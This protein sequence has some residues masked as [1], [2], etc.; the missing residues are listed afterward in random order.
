MTPS[1]TAPRNASVEQSR[2]AKKAKR[3]PNRVAQQ[4]QSHPLGRGDRIASDLFNLAGRSPLVS[5]FLES[6]DHPDR[7]SC[8]RAIHEA[9]TSTAA[10]T[11]LASRPAATATATATAV[12]SA[13]S[14]K[15]EA[16]TEAV[17]EAAAAA[18]P[19]GRSGGAP[20][21][22]SLEEQFGRER[23][24]YIHYRSVAEFS[25]PLA[26]THADAIRDS[27]IEHERLAAEYNRYEY[28]TPPPAPAVMVAIRTN[29]IDPLIYSL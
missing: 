16:E 5:L 26:R 13:R 10:T 29:S 24:R 12:P 2:V 28:L 3:A 1:L 18:P 6:R 7:L 14:I 21:E 27:F 8:L 15:E 9:L 19:S 22:P 4:L 25:D 11:T 23:P 17:L 20:D